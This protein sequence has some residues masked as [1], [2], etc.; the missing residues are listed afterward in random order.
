MVILPQAQLSSGLK[1]CCFKFLNTFSKLQQQQQKSYFIT[2]FWPL[3]WKESTVWQIA[4]LKIRVIFLLSIKLSSP[5]PLPSSPLCVHSLYNNN[6]YHQCNRKY[7]QSGCT[8]LTWL[9]DVWSGVT[10]STSPIPSLRSVSPSCTNTHRFP[11]PE[12]CFENRSF[13]LTVNS[14]ADRYSLTI[15]SVI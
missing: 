2:T 1:C 7:A 14:Q 9:N 13:I 15:L 6:S 4:K 3:S 8:L 12:L 5:S 11:F 10:P